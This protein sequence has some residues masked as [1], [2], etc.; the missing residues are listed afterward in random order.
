LNRSDDSFFNQYF[1][2]ESCFVYDINKVRTNA[3]VSLHGSK[4]QF[5]TIFCKSVSAAKFSVFG[6]GGHDFNSLFNKTLD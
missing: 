1:R 4:V 6:S 3:E 5:F 2:W